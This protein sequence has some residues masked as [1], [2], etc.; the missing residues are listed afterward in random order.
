MGQIR[1]IETV[2]NGYRFRSRLEARWAVFFDAGRIDYEYEPEGFEV[3]AGR[4]LPD[5]YLPSLDTHV[6]VKGVRDGYEK[7][8]LRLREFIRWGGSIRRILIL[9]DVPS[10]TDDGGLWHFPCYYYDGRSDS[11]QGAWWY[12]FDDSGYVS[13]NISHAPYIP[14]S[15]NECDLKVSRFRPVPLFSIAPMSDHSSFIRGQKC[16]APDNSAMREFYLTANYKRN[17]LTFAALNAARQAR[18]EH[19]EKPRPFNK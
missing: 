7:E 8:I 15:I 9:S 5:F 18:F 2:Y 6:E 10:K 11:V 16:D 3:A 4:Y 14:P 19:G 13:G 1:A 12:F 17:N